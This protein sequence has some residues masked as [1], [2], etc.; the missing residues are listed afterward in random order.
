MEETMRRGLVGALM[1][2]SALLAVPALAQQYHYVKVAE[3]YLPCPTGHGDWV[4]YD[5]GNQMV[6]V[7]MKDDGMAV[8]DTRTNTVAHVFKDIP[9]PNVEAFDDNYIYE[10]AAEGLPQ[11]QNGGAA[12]TG[13]GTR[14]EIV[15]IDKHTWQIVDRVGTWPHGTTPDGIGVANGRIYVDMDDNNVM[16]V[17]T[18]GAHPQFVAQWNL[19]PRNSNW[20]WLNT[21]DFTGPDAFGFSP[22]GR[23]IFQSADSYV[24]VIDTSSGAVTRHVDTNVKLTPKGGTKGEVYDPQT[25]HLW[26]STT[27]EKPGVLIMDPSTLQIIKSIPESAGVDELSFDPS[28]RMFY[29]FGGKGFDA[30]DANT[31]EHVA[32]VNTGVGTTHTGAADSANHFVYTYEG[33]RA[34]VGVF[35][36]VPGPGPNGAWQAAAESSGGLHEAALS[37]T[38]RSERLP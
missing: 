33:D 20:W 25:H 14:N 2:S 37:G 36:P 3:I 24:E 35:K 23:E 32:S 17:F 9:A 21:A 22:D 26:V 8:I 38:E 15:V 5:P 27:N 19:Y 11:G 34:A 30:Y 16:N 28:L 4:S 1:A 12:G 31:M 29:A 13:F 7:S 6:Y 18:A 10:T